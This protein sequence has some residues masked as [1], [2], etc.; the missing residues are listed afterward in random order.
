MPF[1]HTSDGVAVH[2]EVH[3]SGEPLVLISGQS[4]SLHW[5][6]RVRED[7]SD[8]F[9]LVVL[10]HRGT[11]KS[12]KPDA[13]VYSTP[14]F[15]EDVV[16]VLDAEGI[17]SAHIYG[18]SMG[19]RIAQ[20]I[21][22]GHPDRV[23]RLVL[24]C[25]SPGGRNAVERSAAVRHSLAQADPHAVRAALLDL[26]YTPAWVAAN[27]GPYF[28]LGDPGMPAHARRWHLRASARHDAWDALPTIAAP[29]LVIHG[30]A[31]EFNP[32]ANAPLL[33]GRIPG[34]L[35]HMIP[36]ARHG[37]FEEFRE[38]ASPLVLDFLDAG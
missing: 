11:G 20:W 4:N 3:G 26:M 10:D 9:T 6:D 5:W 30:T 28:T 16:A 35:L 17:P 13:D 32:A 25:T 1:A 38:T 36:E 22:A 31:D 18:T 27:P 34:A 21:A 7:F 15:A 23:R 24:G 14:R 2:Y 8:R 29:T 37:Y 19:G 12:D 33:A